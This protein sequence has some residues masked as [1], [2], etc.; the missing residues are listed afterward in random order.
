MAWTNVGAWSGSTLRRVARSRQ[1]WLAP[2]ALPAC[3]CACVDTHRVFL[4]HHVFQ[5]ADQKLVVQR[6]KV[7]CPV[8]HVE[9]AAH[10]HGVMTSRAKGQASYTRA[11]AACPSPRGWLHTCVYSCSPTDEDG[12][13]QAEVKTSRSSLRHRTKPQHAKE[14]TN[15]SYDLSPSAC[16]VDTNWYPSI[17]V[18]KRVIRV[19]L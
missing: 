11:C 19:A 2:W 6:R 10:V 17:G 12:A 13:S 18:P 7:H 16:L 14:H 8:R 4:M 15:L 1:S 9:V 3:R 5:V